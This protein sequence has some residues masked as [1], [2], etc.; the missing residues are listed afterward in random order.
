MAQPS[1]TTTTVSFHRP[2]LR[3]ALAVAVAAAT[4]GVSGAAALAAVDEPAAVESCRPNE[5]DLLR[6]ADAA[7]KLEAQRPELFDDGTRS[8][9]SDLRLAAEWARRLE[10]LTPELMC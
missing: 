1:P 6:A 8:R 3:R 10:V 7:R 4:L 5:M 2:T 9:Y